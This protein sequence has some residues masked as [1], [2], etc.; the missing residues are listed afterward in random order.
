[1][2]LVEL[3]IALFIIAILTAFSLPSLRGYWTRTSDRVLQSELQTFIHVAE[4]EA[5]A[6]YARVGVGSSENGRVLL[7]FLDATGDGVIHEKTQII[8]IRKL[9]QGSLA[10]CS[11]PH[12]RKYLQFHPER[13]NSGDDGK[14]W[15]RP[16]ANKSFTWALVISRVGHMHI[17]YPDKP[18]FACRN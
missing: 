18:V 15:Y 14:I 17:S 3:L 9:Q 4:Q 8:A 6:R 10:V 5:R 12:Y 2:K 13:L 11:Y 1:M 7:M 16:A